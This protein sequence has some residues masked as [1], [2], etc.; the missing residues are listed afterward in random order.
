MALSFCFL[1][2]KLSVIDV[3][4]HYQLSAWGGHCLN[5]GGM[6]NVSNIII[7]KTSCNWK[8]H[9]QY[10]TNKLRRTMYVHI[11]ATLDVCMPYR[12]EL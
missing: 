4:H 6:E 11:I 9:V 7:Y 2:F 12:K 5:I 10:I 1:G 3:I 8:H